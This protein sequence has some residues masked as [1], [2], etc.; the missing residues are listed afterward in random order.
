[1]IVDAACEPSAS[2]PLVVSSAEPFSTTAADAA[3]PGAGETAPLPP[4]PVPVDSNKFLEAEQADYFLEQ[5][6]AELKQRGD[7]LEKQSQLLDL[8]SH[9]H[10]SA[11]STGEMMGQVDFVML[12]ARPKRNGCIPV[13]LEK[14]SLT[15]QQ[16]R[17]LDLRHASTCQLGPSCIHPRCAQSRELWMHINNCP[18][19]TKDCKFPS[20]ESSKQLLE[21]FRKCVSANNNDCE[22][23][24]VVMRKIRFDRERVHQA[25]QLAKNSKAGFWA[26]SQEIAQQQ[27][28]QLQ[29][30]QSFMQLQELMMAGTPQQIENQQ[31]QKQMRQQAEELNKQFLAAANGAMEEPTAGRKSGKKDQRH[32]MANNNNFL[33]TLT[34]QMVNDPLNNV[35]TRQR[36]MMYQAENPSAVVEEAPPVPPP[37]HTVTNAADAMKQQELAAQQPVY[38]MP[39]L[40]PEQ[41]QKHE[42]FLENQKNLKQVSVLIWDLEPFVDYWRCHVCRV[43]SCRVVSKTCPAKNIQ[44]HSFISS[45]STQRQRRRRRRRCRCQLLH[46]TNHL[47]RSSRRINGIIV[48]QMSESREA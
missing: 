45:N 12:P 32:Q 5:Q 37:L 22:N 3:P 14:V 18:A 47:N 36:L 6:V 4:P 1:M 43:V 28:Q 9:E 17:L 46:P 23:C 2:D 27:Q 31:Q 10:P 20:C 35:D 42:Q 13:G 30:Q 48:V 44:Y 38:I 15:P 24:S 21:H 16:S 29:E 11:V 26:Q 41:Q 33:M 40:T 39:T 34:C 7:F 19:S 8:P 25:S